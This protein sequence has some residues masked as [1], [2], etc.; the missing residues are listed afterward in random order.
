M[1]GRDLPESESKVDR[2][3][4]GPG[5]RLAA[6]LCGEY[7]VTEWMRGEPEC[8]LLAQHGIAHCGLM[9]AR[10]STE[11]VRGHQS[12]TYMLA[13]IEGEGV[14]LADG[15]WKRIGAGQACLL[16]PFVTNAFKCLPGKSWSFVW[17]R[18][19][20]SRDTRPIVTA[21]SPVSGC[22]DGLPLKA[23]VEG[24]RAECLGE[25]SLPALHHWAELIHQYVLRF[26]QPH[27]TDERLWRVWRKVEVDLAADWTL[28]GLARIACVSGEHLRRMCHKELGRSPM[29]HLTHLRLQRAR[30]ILSTSNDKIEAVARQVGFESVTSFSNTFLKWIGCRPS[31][32]RD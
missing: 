29:Q 31:A 6:V 10:P 21:V 24:L 26:A 14:V 11:I 18:Y 30:E 25:S 32:F 20:E 13:C 15:R 12:G 19:A 27:T 16:P 1:A 22:F 2:E 4:L 8:P 9:L 23:A 17:V 28:D 7:E 3:T 5:S